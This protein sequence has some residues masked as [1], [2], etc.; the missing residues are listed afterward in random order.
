MSVEPG[1][2]IPGTGLARTHYPHRSLGDLSRCCLPPP[3]EGS[4]SEGSRSPPPTPV[5][6]GQTE[7][8]PNK[9]QTACSNRKL[10]ETLAS[11]PSPLSGTDLEPVNRTGLDLLPWIFSRGRRG[12]GPVILGPTELGGLAEEDLFLA[13]M[14]LVW[15][16]VEYC[17]EV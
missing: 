7:I 15:S 13:L 12:L 1:S 9:Q 4:W 11:F 10:N 5:R 17:R 6:D 8:K 14:V 2:N 3:S 16:M